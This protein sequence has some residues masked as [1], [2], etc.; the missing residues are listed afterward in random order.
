MV[1]LSKDRER[2]R[3]RERVAT[4]GTRGKKR[5]EENG[6]I[7]SPLAGGRAR[8]AKRICLEGEEG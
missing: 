6:L 3:E 8:E 1:D 4:R 5:D 7:P 2:E